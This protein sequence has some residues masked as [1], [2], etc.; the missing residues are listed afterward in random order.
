M[1]G[2]P[3]RTLIAACAAGLLAVILPAVSVAQA[4][5]TRF[6]ELPDSG[7]FAAYPED[8]AQVL[9][10]V[11]AHWRAGRTVEA[12]RYAMYAPAE[13]D[14]ALVR[15][16]LANLPQL[17]TPYYFLLSR[18]TFAESPADA[19]FWHMVAGV[20]AFYDAGRCA[21]GGDSDRVQYLFSINRQAIA[22]KEVVRQRGELAPLLERAVQWLRGHPGLPHPAYLCAV[23]T[24]E[25]EAQQQ[26]EDAVD[27]L[28][29][30]L[31]QGAIP[32]ASAQLR[33]LVEEVMEARQ[34][35][36]LA[37]L[38]IE[39]LSQADEIRNPRVLAWAQ[40]APDE[41]LRE[42]L[43]LSYLKY[44]D[45]AIAQ[46]AYDFH[47]SPLGQ[48]MV[49]NA[50][51]ERLGLGGQYSRLTEEEEAELAEWMAGPELQRM[52]QLRP[53]VLEYQGTL[54]RMAAGDPA[55]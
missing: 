5:L 55:L 44:W 23:V 16:L 15:W 28:E 8:S 26:R 32:A 33:G 53:V 4:D 36:L 11:G 13:H 39:N 14:R 34:D 52:N 42:Y 49:Q 40:S 31:D 9:A 47:A 29:A 3:V 45:E 20:N 17:S 12:V 7:E 24:A 19:V 1:T 21:L 54:L 30:M 38:S 25:D 22:W 48:K 46:A 35:L 51:N 50:I 6:A 10:E 2:R 41:L 18:K 43:A 27:R 37:R